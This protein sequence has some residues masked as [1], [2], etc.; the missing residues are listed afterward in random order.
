MNALVGLGLGAQD[1]TSKQRTAAAKELAAQLGNTQTAVAKASA[2][3]A[4][5]KAATSTSSS[6][7]TRSTGSDLDENA[8][9]EL[10]VCQLQNQDPLNPTDNSEMIAQLAQFSSLEQMTN[11]NTSFETL[12]G[13][14]DQL[15]FVSANALIGQ[16]VTGSDANGDAYSG[17]V[18][19]VVMDS[20]NGV[21]V[22]VDN[23]L[24]PLS[25]I[26]QVG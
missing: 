11:L 10:L 1:V 19:Q 18:T 22:V 21:C 26:E 15:S 14:V 23:T 5:A 12:S 3:V 9:L 13:N 25:S 4:A 20:T 7:S 24:I 6:S 17:E 16:T 2:A 8:F